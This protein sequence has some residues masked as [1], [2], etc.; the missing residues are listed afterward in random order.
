MGLLSSSVSITRYKVHGKLN[1][2]IIETVAQGLKKNMV[3]EIDGKVDDKTVGWT[4]FENPFQPR[5]DN[6]SFVYGNYF[7]FALRID[8][9]NISVKVLQKHTSMESARRMA[10]SGRDYLT[11]TEKKLV[12]DHVLNVLSLK[13]P[14]TPSIY[15][16]IWA[17]ENE[18]LW[19]F[20]NLKTANEELETLFPKSFKLSL[21]RLFPY[22]AADISS[23][24]T[25]S[26]RDGL[27]RISP[28][29]FVT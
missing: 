25:N 22:F 5:F 4:S 3:L 19:F 26:E 17:Y 21:I 23:G 2:P 16:V 6:S 13:I 8:K 7:V 12:K 9:K 29:R 20:S 1:Y 14:A 27:K 15:D 28:T 18:V 24:L 11:K 10:E